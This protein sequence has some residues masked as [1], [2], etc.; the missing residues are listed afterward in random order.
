MNKILTSFVIPHKGREQLLIETLHSIC[1]QDFD[2]EYIEIILVT[3]NETISDEI[4][5]I[6][7]KVSFSIFFRPGSDTISSLRNYG[8]KHAKGEY[9][10]FLDA[11]IFLSENWLNTMLLTLKEDQQCSLV[12]AIQKNSR[13]APILEQI[14]TTLNNTVMD[15]NVDFLPGSNLF[16]KKETFLKVGGF[17]ED[18]VTCE[19][20]I[21]TD[22]VNQDGNL[23]CT[24]RATFIHLGED[25]SYKQMFY[26]EIWRG[27]SNFTSLKGRKIA[28]SELPSLLIPLAVF[29]LFILLAGSLIAGNGAFSLFFIFLLFLPVIAYSLRLKKHA[30]KKISFWFIMKFY[31]YYFPARMIGSITGLFKNVTTKSHN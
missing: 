10:T 1:L 17:P 18:M 24:S 3:Q 7:E 19:D 8:A 27:Q 12:S 25:K 30:K 11:D 29:V 26:K 2:L 21:F 23:Y 15:G 9:L 20:F 13:E 14:R 16:L 31:I 5:S 28:F 22:R 6:K 4:K